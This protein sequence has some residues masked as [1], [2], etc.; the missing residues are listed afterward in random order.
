MAFSSETA[1]GLVPADDAVGIVAPDPVVVPVPQADELAILDTLELMLAPEDV[2]ELRALYKGSKKRTDSGYFDSAHWPKLAKEAHMLSGNGAAV[3]ITLNPVDPQLLSRCHNRVESFAHHTTTD[4]QVTRRRWLL[5]DLDPVR[6]SGISASNAQL[7]DA[8]QVA[9]ALARYLKGLGWPTATVAMSG[10]G[11][12]LLYAIDLPNDDASKDLLAA[13][14]KVL[15]AKFDTHG[16]KVDTTVYNAARIVK[17]YGTVANKGDHTPAAP[18]RLSQLIRASEGVPVSKT[19]LLDLAAA[20]QPGSRQPYP[21]TGAL[22]HLLAN[23]NLDDFLSRHAIEFKLDQHDGRE[24]YKLATCPFN[25]EHING[26]SAIFRKPSGE[27]GFKCMHDSCS[28]KGWREVRDLLAGP[29]PSG[30][31]VVSVGVVDAPFSKLWGQPIPLPS[32]L[33]PVDPFVEDL[34][35]ATLRAWVMDIAHRMQC[36]ADFT[37]VGA[38]VALSSLIGARAVIQPKARDDW[39]VVPNLWGMT[40]GRPGVKKSPALGE[41]LKPMGRLQAKASEDFTAV[42]NAWVADT[43]LAAVLD[44]ANE[45]AAKKIAANNPQGARQLLTPKS[46]PEEPTVRRYLVNDA[47]V[48]KLGELMQQNPWGT[49]SYRDELYGLLTSLDKQGQEG[50]RAFYLQSYDGNQG[51]TFDRIMRGTVHISRVCLAMIGGIQP[52]RIQEYVRGAVSGGSGDDGLLQRF[53]LAVWP[54]HTGTYTHV[55]EWPNSSAKELAWQVFQRLAA[56]QPTSE[57]EPTVW[58]FSPAA[59]KIFVDWL[60]PFENELRG[61]TLH[62]AMV[63]HLAKYRKLIPALALIFAMVDTPDSG[64]EIHEPELSRALA[65]GR[66]L[67]THA[68]RLYAAGVAP[69]TTNAAS[70][71]AKIKANTRGGQDAMALTSFTPRQIVQKGW[72]GLGDTDA[73]RKAADLLVDYGWLHRE[74][75][76]SAD[77]LGRGRNSER[78]VVHPT[79]L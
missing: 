69:E 76:Q 24:R 62:P 27:L 63:S 15:A 4:K 77:E 32:G 34:L 39:Q 33:P 35:P 12:H 8:K 78:Y 30:V 74:V 72:A 47:T 61:D 18:W 53:G 52:G 59:Q 37:A 51:Y 25:P 67:R 57:S 29:R 22:S 71:M 55:D 19:Q 54:D 44:A 17:L 7:S 10:N 16:L 42:H 2:V 73:V 43:K 23:F 6:P 46:K 49:L 26:E 68:N 3:Y 40:V 28:G 64:G 36:P 20:L 58:R 9:K 5:V 50:S 56:L 21:A 79:L 11:F 38:L 48:E 45:K 75:V 14:L 60:V 66:Y 65:W 13:V 70:L 1:F 41:V 31:S